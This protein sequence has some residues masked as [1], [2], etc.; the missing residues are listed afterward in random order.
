[1]PNPQAV[2]WDLDG[3]LVD[4]GSYH[5]EAFRQLMADRGRHLTEAEFGRLLGLR[6]DSILRA[7]L[8]ELPPD[9]ME[10]LAARK[11]GLFRRLIAG[12]VRALP[13]APVLV[14]R[15]CAAR[16]PQAIVSST[17]R[18]NIEL[19]LR[20]LGMERKFAVVVGEEDA[21]RGK[22]DPEGFLT[23]AIRLGVAPDGCVV[24][25][26]APEGVAAAKRAGMRVIGVATTR[27]P[28]Q[29][30]EADLVVESLENPAVEALL[31]DR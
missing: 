5:Y 21:S 9:E 25:E 22:P 14:D 19:I 4:S 16:V 24:L 28:E 7:L 27:R 6:N 17:P 11:E 10:A 18:A 12:R 13:G 2:L 1:M 23:A 15:L 31:S 26:D 29:L 8:G 3:V 30:S 20:S